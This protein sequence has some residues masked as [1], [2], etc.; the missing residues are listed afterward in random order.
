MK[1]QKQGAPTLVLGA[2][3]VVFG[4]IGTSPLY[5]IHQ[6]FSDLH[7]PKPGA[8][9]VLGILSL[10]FWS[11]I[12]V[13]CIKYVTFVLRADYNGEGGTLALLGLIRTEGKRKVKPLGTARP[14]GVC[15]L[16]AALWRRCHHAFH[17]RPVRGGGAQGGNARLRSPTSCPFVWRSSRAFS[18]CNASARAASATFSG[19]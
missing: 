6:C 18:F 7:N 4:D 15:R 9:E 8:P 13:V 2:L 12:L 5:A 11:L 3:G 14:D 17:F 1:P 19:P 10:V 16:R